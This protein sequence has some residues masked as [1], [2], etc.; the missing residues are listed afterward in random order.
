[1]LKKTKQSKKNHETSLMNAFMLSP[2]IICILRGPNHVFELANDMYLQ[3]IGNRDIIN[4]PIQEALPELA[5][6]GFFELL[7]KVYKTGE[8]ITVN[9]M[10]AKLDIGN[11]KFKEDY[12][13]FVY[14]PSYDANECV[15]GIYVHA[16]AVTEQVLARKKI[17]ESEHRFNEM[18]NSSPSL[19]SIFKGEN[20][21]ID[22]AND[23]ILESWGKGNIIGQSLFD[24][25]PEVIE[26]GFDTLLLGVYKTGEPVKANEIPAT[27]LRNGIKELG[28]YDFIYQAQRNK[29]GDIEGVAVLANEVTLRVEAK[30][31]L[32]ESEKR[33]RN[34]VEKATNPILILKGE[35]MIVELANAPMLTIWQVGKEAIGKC[36]LDI[37]PEIKDQ[38][39]LGYLFNV[40]HNGV[41]LHGNEELGYFVR[42]NG[43]K[44][45]GYYNFVYQPY[46]EDDGS[47]SGVMVTATDV[48]EQVVA[49][50]K[51]EESEERF[52]AAVAAVQGIV[53][54][55]NAKGEMEGE[56]LGWHLLTGQN[57]EAY[58]GYGWTDA[59][60]PDDAQPTI[61]AWHEAVRNRKHFVFEHRVR[62]KNGEWGHFSVKA[63]PLLNA[64]GSIREWVGVHTDITE[65]KEANNKAEAAALSAQEAMKAKQQFLSNM[66]HEIRTPMNAIVGF[67]N[68][69]L[70]T[71]L[72]E[73][74]KEYINAIKTSGDSLIVLIDD[75]LDLAKVDAG[76]MVFQHTPFKLFECIA[77]MLHLFDIK[78][79]EKN[80]ALVKEY[81]AT[82]P[83]VLL[84][85]AVRLQQIFINLINNAI[86]FTTKGKITV[87][88]RLVNE[89]DQQATIEFTITDTGVGIAQNKLNHIFGAFEQ[90]HSNTSLSYGGTGLGLAIVKQLVEHQGGTVSVKSKE[91]EGSTFGFVLPF[92]KTAI[93][94]ATKTAT[95]GIPTLKNLKI[96]VAEDVKLNQ[97]LIRII[98]EDFGVEVDMADNGKLAIEK[99]KTTP[100]DII[101]MDLQMPEM[102]GFEATAY[103]RNQL[104]SNI[105]IIAL[106][107]DVTTVDVEKCKAIGMNDYISKPIDEKLLYEKIIKY[108]AKPE[109]II[110]K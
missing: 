48:T 76:K 69:V 75:I 109:I 64:D 102:N 14:Q 73:K 21:I 86:K 100:Y 78:I 28:Y 6:Q 30:N 50:K 2:A 95:E 68:V 13:N 107:A 39:F 18:V 25:L 55:N 92:E 106:T 8:T 33:F 36:L 101:L 29:K 11:G 45:I 54:T 108:L 60:H 41:T 87:S 17:E 98:L 35:N 16:I 24:A 79:Q 56:Q 91:G 7:D 105:P 47:I 93:E 96:L 22:I 46:N 37:M 34:L 72:D 31:K 81:D 99:L 110:P 85:D 88:A 44:E 38:P 67:T 40:L 3:L 26:Q 32:F 43:E 63:I 58:Q 104:H 5:G 74:Q 59:I 62:L 15:N 12:F 71:T 23:A 90:A 1:M 49:R 77:T 20:M 53:W 9:E 97:L 42:E 61:E 4:K 94:A 27:M 80:I 66:S 52:Q 103:I 10:P 89:D 51:I 57:D 65:Q 82:I 84:G 70:K 83:E 19:I